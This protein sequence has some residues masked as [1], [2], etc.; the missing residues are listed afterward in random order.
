MDIGVGSFVFA[1]GLMQARKP[2]ASSCNQLAQ[3]FSLA[4]RRCLPL[5]ALGFARLLVV[6]SSNYQEHVTE[7]GMHWNFF[8]TLACLPPLMV[9]IRLIFNWLSDFAVCTILTC[10]KLSLISTAK[11]QIFSLFGRI[12]IPLVVPRASRMDFDGRSYKS[13][14]G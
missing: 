6:K 8:F 7:Y 1:Q 13:A 5:F 12:S 3:Q 10:G 14:G 2:M 9:W 11:W 4:I